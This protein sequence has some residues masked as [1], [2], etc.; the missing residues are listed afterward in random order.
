M[1][2][3]LTNGLGPFL[4]LSSKAEL[5]NVM[6]RVV[7]YRNPL[8]SDDCKITITIVINKKNKIHNV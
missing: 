8:Y 4:G 1:N 5:I 6:S 3:F 7:S 2:G